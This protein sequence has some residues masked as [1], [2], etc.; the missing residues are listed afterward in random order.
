MSD[1]I[2]LKRWLCHQLEKASKPSFRRWSLYSLLL[3]H[4]L[5]LFIWGWRPCLLRKCSL[6]LSSFL[7]LSD[8][9]ILTL[10]DQ[11]QTPFLKGWVLKSN[12]RLVIEILRKHILLLTRLGIAA[13][14]ILGWKPHRSGIRNQALR[15][16][17]RLFWKRRL[18]S[19]HTF[20]P[21]SRLLSHWQIFK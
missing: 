14:K 15:H 10:C 5:F 20:Q 11:F 6:S 2:F 18:I 9:Y 7:F 21:I 1:M 19:Q 12:Q 3:L 13:V 16:L 4:L 8:R 17:P